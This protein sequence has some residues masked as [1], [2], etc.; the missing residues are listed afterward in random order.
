MTET[1]PFYEA[2]LRFS[3]TRCS[4]CC[5]HEP[6]YVFLSQ[7]D[8]EL[9]AEA[10]NMKYTGVMQKYCRWVPAPGGGK[11]LSLKEKPGYD[12]ILWQD[13]CTVYRHR[14]LQCRTFPFW[15][16]TLGSPEAWNNL[17]FSCPGVG[18]GTLHGRDSIQSCL[19]Q[20]I[21]EPVITR[22]A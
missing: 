17:T 7:N 10:L 20:R 5:R 19:D 3:C 9:L 4:S 21:A 11:Q 12:C 8:L 13:G 22:G 18:K 16:S 1:S 14:P 15:H 6:G 2:G